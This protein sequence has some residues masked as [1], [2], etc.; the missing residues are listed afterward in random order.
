MSARDW[1]WA[2]WPLGA[3]MGLLDALSVIDRSTPF[4]TVVGMLIF[5]GATVS[6]A[7]WARDAWQRRRIEQR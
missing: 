6:G 3:V 2:I 7:L 1:F 4:W 5:C